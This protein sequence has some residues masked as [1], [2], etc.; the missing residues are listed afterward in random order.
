MVRRGRDEGNAGDGVARAGY[1]LVHLEAGQLSAFAGLGSLRHLDLYLLGVHQVFRGHA[2]AARSHLLG[3]A[4]EGDAVLL[5]VEAAG[6]L[7]SLARV[8]AR[9]QLV[10]RQGQSFVRLLADGAEGDGAR[11]EV[12][13]NLLHRLHLFNGY[14]LAAEAEEVAQEDWMLLL[15]HQPGELLELG[16]AAQA[17]GQLQGTDGVG[18]PGMLLAVLAV[19]HLPD[20]G[21]QILHLV[22][23]ESGLMEDGVIPRNLLQADAAD[24]GGGRAEVVLQQL[25]AHA[26]GLEYLR[27]AVGTDGAD[28]HLA[29]YL[30]KSLAKGLDVIL[31]RRLVVQLHVAAAHQV[32]QHGKGHVGVD[33]AGA[34]AQQEGGVHHL[35]D[36]AAL[37]HEGGLHTLLHAYQVVVHRADGQQRGDGRMGGIHVAVGQ[38]E[39][40]GPFR[41]RFFRPAAQFRQGFLQ[42]GL[43]P[44]CGE[45]HRQLDG[46]EALVADVAEDIQ[47]RVGQNGMRQAYH[48]AMALVGL[49]DVVAHGTDVLR[50]RHHQF[51]ADGVDGRI[52]DLGELLAEIVE[53]QL[54]QVR[55]DGQGRVVAHGGRGFGTCGAHRH[56]DALHILAGEAEGAQAAVVVRHGVLHLAA[57][58][59]G[60]QLDAVG[61][62]PAAVGTGGSQLFLQRAIVVDLTLLRVHHQDFARL[63]AAFLLDILRLKADDARLAGHH[64]H[65]V[66]GDE[67]AGGAQAVAVQH[68]ARIASVAEEQGGG[69]V[70]RLHQDGVVFI[71]SLQVL[72]DGVLVIERFG[73]QHRHGMGQA[74][75]GHHEELQHV[76]QRGTVAHTGLQDG[77]DGLDVA[78]GRRGQHALPGLH[79]APVAADG[80]DFA[81]VCQ[82]AERLSQAP[83]G[84]GVGAE[85]GVHDGQSAGEVGLCQV[86]EVLAHLHG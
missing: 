52:G 59:Q 20:V 60:V 79:P 42:S 37:H 6:V 1:H 45:E 54:R 71:E 64:H 66:L 57:T 65:V 22:R 74:E 38:D 3:L 5:A 36:F 41:H 11:D 7:A 28:A 19:G 67:V 43:A 47:L 40:V 24:G 58:A 48:L 18:I 77:A 63:Q 75:A 46:L 56:H 80:V 26:H 78:Q 35:A 83:R 16:V 44:A 72:A 30:V 86:E 69:T 55:E 70:P 53:Q 4:A 50:Q 27:A 15:V 34:V 31:L 23:G 73:H 25:P 8:A 84:E 14:R 51:L 33:G 61:R 13:D 21:Q 17:G 81:V 49:E 62:Q 82:Q 9:A 85:A 68:A 32:V 39:V 76:V 2:E 10:H 12:L 29:H